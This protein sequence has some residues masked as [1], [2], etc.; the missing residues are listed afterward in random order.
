MHARTLNALRSDSYLWHW[1]AVII[2]FRPSIRGNRRCLGLESMGG[3]R[4][5]AVCVAGFGFKVS[6]P[7]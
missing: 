1:E 4:G 2:S 6:S 5:S 3:A 7:R